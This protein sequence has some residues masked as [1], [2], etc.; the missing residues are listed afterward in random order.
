M[1]SSDL[2]QVGSG[3]P[4]GDPLI[5]TDSPLAPVAYGDYN[6]GWLAVLAVERKGTLIAVL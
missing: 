2:V 6:I 1:C 4:G 5:S 3:S